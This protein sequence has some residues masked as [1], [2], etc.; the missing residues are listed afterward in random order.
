[1]TTENTAVGR[2][3]SQPSHIPWLG[4]KA[5]LTRV[6]KTIGNADISLRCAGV[7]FFGFLSI[8]PV[9]ACFVL[10][11]GLFSTGTSLQEHLSVIREFAPGSVYEILE[12]RL[13]ALL[14]QPEVGLGV[15]LIISF[16]LALWSGSRG[17]NSLIS[18]VSE[19][20]REPEERGFLAAAILSVGLTLGGLFFVLVALFAIAA[21]PV[22]VATLP[23]PATAETIALWVRWPLLAAMVW[24]ALTILYRLAPNRKGAQWKWITPGSAVAT[25][26]WIAASVGFSIYVEQFGNYGAT[27]GS[28]SVVVVMMLWIYYSTMIIAIGAAL[29][30]EME[31]QTKIDTTTGPAAPMGMRGAHVADHLPEQ[32]AS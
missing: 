26:L 23:F 31:H 27:F 7:A 4:W 6:Y 28:L 29:N 2:Y 1:M 14:S 13:Q 10:I 16:C 17:T 3:A 9:M 18:T 19:S 24:V 12:E 21:I 25:V 22:I 8:F 5:I 30:A 20:Y 32:S 11:Y 15:G